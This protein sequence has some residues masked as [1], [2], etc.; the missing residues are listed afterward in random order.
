MN[1]LELLTHTVLF[2]LRPPDTAAAGIYDVIYIFLFLFDGSSRDEFG[3]IIT[4]FAP[5]H[6]RRTYD[7]RIYRNR[8]IKRYYYTFSYSFFPPQMTL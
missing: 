7:R 2:R 8:S 6:R 5:S 1:T 3:F 4:I